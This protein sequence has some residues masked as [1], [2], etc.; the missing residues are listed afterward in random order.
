ME[1]FRGKVDTTSDALLLFE[2]CRLGQLKRVSRR[3]T[4][5]ERSTHVKSGAVFVWDEDES[6]IKR[7][8]DGKN[9]SPSRI[10]NSFL[11]YREIEPR[12]RPP[13]KAPG[14]ASTVAADFVLKEKG[15]VKKALSIST[16]DSKR[17]HL[18][19]YYY[20]DET[21]EESPLKTP[22]SLPQFKDISIPNE[23][24]P[25]FVPD[26]QAGSFGMLPRG[27]S[28]L[29]LISAEDRQLIH[30]F[31]IR[32]YSYTCIRKQPSG[33]VRTWHDV[34]AAECADDTVWRLRFNGNVWTGTISSAIP[35]T[36]FLDV[37]AFGR[38]RCHVGS[39]LSR[40]AAA[41][42]SVV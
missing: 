10:H 28:G 26:G 35:R 13:P 36:L 42:V 6:G 18:V 25:E 16:A 37:E 34:D 38:I 15:L 24:Y 29:S 9:W 7:W 1:T 39:L 19:S 3:L 5:N 30:L 20:K 33:S 41:V 12:Q 40:N 8:T 4:E 31:Y 27:E 22:S 32:T 21:Q 17:Q 11:L 14:E 2:S 23:M